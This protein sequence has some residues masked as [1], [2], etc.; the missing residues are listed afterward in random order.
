MQLDTRQSIGQARRIGER[1]PGISRA[2]RPA[3][4]QQVGEG[5][6]IFAIEQQDAAIRR[7]DQPRV[8]HHAGRFVIE[9]CGNEIG[10]DRDVKSRRQRAQTHRTGTCERAGHRPIQDEQEAPRDVE[11]PV[12]RVDG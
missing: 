9:Q 11:E 8:A 2:H 5:D 1:A 10:I 4:D 3:G 6:G 12:C 7:E